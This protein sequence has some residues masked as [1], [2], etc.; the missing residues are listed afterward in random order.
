MLTLIFPKHNQGVLA[1][2]KNINFP[3]ATGL[4]ALS[5]Y[6]K[7]RKSSI[8]VS[9]WDLNLYN[10]LPVND[11]ES[12]LY[13]LSVWFS[14][15]QSDLKLAQNIKS[16]WPKSKIILGGHNVNSIEKRILENNPYID[17]VISGDGEIGLLKLLECEVLNKVPGLTY[18]S[19][20]QIFSNPIQQVESLDELPLITLENLKTP[21]NWRNDCANNSAFPISGIRGCMRQNRCDY[22]SIPTVSVRKLSTKR[23]WQQLQLLMQNYGITRFFETGDIFDNNYARALVRAK[24]EYGPYPKLRVYSYPGLINKNNIDTYL[25]LGVDNVF[26]GVESVLIWD[27]SFTK[28][29]S[30]NYTIQSLIAEID[31]LWDHGI[32]T[33]PSFILGLP[34]ETYD[35]L[36][37]NVELIYRIAELPGT[38]ELLINSPIPLPNS[39]YFNW[40]IENEQIVKEYRNITGDNLRTYDNLNYHILSELFVNTYTEVSYS[41]IRKKI[42]EM[43]K[44]L[45]NKVANWG[46]GSEL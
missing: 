41:L 13:G 34:G 43:Q 30:S 26:I 45:F 36:E 29:Y 2:K 17:Y 23:Y 9:V 33:M 7:F 6:L 37:R 42:R 15:Y 21:F 31:L 19:N 32:T 8:N 14:N 39:N 35:T 10:Y 16:R 24:P 11:L 4:L 5:N 40:C 12:E 46:V 27:K 38:Q 22:C 18:R 20:G 1:D 25:Q 3:P 44:I 28:K